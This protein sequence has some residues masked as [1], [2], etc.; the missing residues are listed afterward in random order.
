VLSGYN[1]KTSCELNDP[2]SVPTSPAEKAALQ[3]NN[4]DE[5]L[6]YVDRSFGPSTLLLAPPNCPVNRAKAI[7]LHRGD[8]GVAGQVQSIFLPIAPDQVTKPQLDE[9]KVIVG[10]T[11]VKLTGKN[12][13]LI[14]LNGIM[15]NG[16]AFPA[17]IARDGSLYPC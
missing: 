14:A 13:E 9:I 7:E 1:P 16:T 2:E 15:Y 10:D 6:A 17:Q 4:C 5:S 3:E 8:N 11:S 12:L